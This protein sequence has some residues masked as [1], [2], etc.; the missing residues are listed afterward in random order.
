MEA[1]TTDPEVIVKLDSSVQ[2]PVVV[3]AFKL[4]AE[5]WWQ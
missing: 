2:F 5:H 4:E 1:K 3:K